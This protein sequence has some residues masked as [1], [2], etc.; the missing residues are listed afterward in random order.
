MNIIGKFLTL[1]MLL[2]QVS[3]GLETSF[4][5]NI[6]ID[7]HFWKI[8]NITGTFKASCFLLSS[9]KLICVCLKR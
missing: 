4:Q 8:D 6:L 2:L 3:V 9:L 1:C 5:R 7:I